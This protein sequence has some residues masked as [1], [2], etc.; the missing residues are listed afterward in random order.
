MNVGKKLYGVTDFISD[1]RIQ[2][3][4]IIKDNAK[5]FIVRD[6]IEPFGTIRIYKSDPMVAFTPEDAVR[7]YSLRCDAMIDK[8]NDRIYVLKDRVKVANGLL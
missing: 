3:T 1:V 6:R 8:L 5:T 2:N 4:E 7:L